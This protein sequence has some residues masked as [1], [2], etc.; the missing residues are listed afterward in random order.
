MISRQT[1]SPL[2]HFVVSLVA[3]LPAVVNVTGSKI[4]IHTCAAPFMI[5]LD[6]QPPFPADIGIGIKLDGD[7]F[8]KRIVVTSTIAQTVTFFAGSAEVFSAGIVYAREA[9]TYA[10][11]VDLAAIGAG[12]DYGPFLP[13]AYGNTKQIIITNDSIYRIRID[14]RDRQTAVYV[15]GAVIVANSSFVIDGGIAF[16]LHNMGAAA[17]NVYL[18]GLY[19]A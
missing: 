19:Y 17:A 14:F 1:H 18:V 12:S 13:N 6:Q 10:V 16:Q 15:P 7:D 5:G 3:N 2:A 9:P 4:W 11:P 8:F